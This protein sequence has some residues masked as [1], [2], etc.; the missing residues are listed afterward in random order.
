MNAVQ[1]E[2]DREDSPPPPT[3]NHFLLIDRLD[4]GDGTIYGIRIRSVPTVSVGFKN[5]FL[6]TGLFILSPY[7]LTRSI[8]AKSIILYSYRLCGTIFCDLSN[9][10]LKI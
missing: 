8:F 10:D 9:P 1:V 7:S 4:D 6:E 2:Q 5:F 3:T